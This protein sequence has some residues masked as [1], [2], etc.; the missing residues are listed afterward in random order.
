M[1]ALRP[2]EKQVG[3]MKFE[4][5]KNKSY[6]AAVVRVPATLPLAGLDRLV[7][8][9]VLG[10]QALTQK[11]G[12]AVSDLKIVFT[13]ETQLSHEYCKANNLYRDATLNAD[14][15]EVGYIETNRRIKALKLRGHR[16]DALLMPLESLAYTGIDPADLREGDVFDVANGQ[17]I[18]CKYEVAKKHAQNPAK[19]KV[20]R[21]FRRVDTK[22]FPEHLSTSQYHREKHLLRDGIEIV[23]T[24][25]LHGTSLRVGRVPCLRQ[26]GRIERLVNRWIKTPDY[27]YDV[28]Y[29]SRKVIKDVNNP[30]QDHWYASDIWSEYGSKI[31]DLIPEGWIVYGE[32]IGWTPDG[33]PLQKNY[34]YNAPKGECEL[35]VYRVATINAQGTLADLPWDAVKTFCLERGLKWTP[36]LARIPSWGDPE[37]NFDGALEDWYMDK[38]YFDSR[39]H[40]TEEPV[41]LSDGKT[42]DEGVCLRQE[43]HGLVPL[44]L[45][46]K[47]PKFLQHETKLLDEEILDI[48]SAA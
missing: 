34:T 21:A 27:E 31:A 3:S 17:A 35:Y 39:E 12:A 6:A 11:D 44:L 26:K 43:G 4:E 33:A 29:G 47:A 48:E 16:S 41:P 9:P 15:R 1:A 25:K 2:T 32:L 37:L 10:H 20:E 28:V 38:R 22:I 19:S 42:V 24:Q 18:C 13:A 23:V 7:G 5:P 45:K 30:N 8:V 36:E 46:A 40:F 14:I